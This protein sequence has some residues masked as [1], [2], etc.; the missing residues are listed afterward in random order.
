MGFYRNLVLVAASSTQA[1]GLCPA[2]RC[3]SPDIR[4]EWGELSREDRLSYISAVQCM[5]DRPPELSVEEVPAVR[6]RYD[7]FTAVHI[8]YTLQVHNSGTFLPWHRHF[9]WLWEKALREECGF[10][11]TLPYWDWVMWPNLAA[12]PLFDGTETSLSGDGEFNAAEQPA[13]LN[14]EPGLTIT[15]PRGAGGGCVRSGPFKDWV[16]NMGPFAFNESYEPALPDHA[17]DYNPR[18]L[19]RS[20]NDWLIQTYNNQTV[21]DTLLDAPD[22]VEFQNIMG[23]FP[24]P[25]I[26]LG[27]H[28]TGHR[29][30]G[31]DMLDFFASTQDPAFWQH[32]GMVDRLWTMW[33]D[34]D[35]PW[36]RFALNGSST[37]WYKDDTPEVTLQTTV[38]FGILD[39]PRPL[40]ELMSPTAGLYCYTY[41]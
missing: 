24:N 6:S 31:P 16:I 22:I 19:V 20:L 33:Q 40:Y 9:I 11:G 28:H 32:H 14:P 7:D 26:P 4:Y 37:T 10:T 34:A 12:S 39:H 8:N 18:C 2:T 27:P 3:D 38:E 15:V 5:K 36:R 13:Q 41:T 23:G 30:L 17:F 21:V 35:E 29:S 1:L 25:P